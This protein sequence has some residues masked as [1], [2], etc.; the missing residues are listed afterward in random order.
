MGLICLNAG[1]SDVNTGQSMRNEGKMLDPVEALER[2]VERNDMQRTRLSAGTRLQA[3]QEV[4]SLIYNGPDKDCSDFPDTIS[5][6]GY[7]ILKKAGDKPS[8]PARVA[9]S[10]IDTT[11]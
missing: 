3:G 11:S 5:K 9:T 1:W 10:G 7:R 8:K 6:D 4:T 2:A